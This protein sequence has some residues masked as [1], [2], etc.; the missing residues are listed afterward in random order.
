MRRRDR[1]RRGRCGCKSGNARRR[2]RQ[3]VRARI[4]AAGATKAGRC[5]RHSV[6][7]LPWQGWYRAPTQEAQA[8]VAAKRAVTCEAAS[9][10]SNK[11][12][13]RHVVRSGGLHNQ[14][15]AAAAV[16]AL[17]AWHRPVAAHAGNRS[18]R[19]TAGDRA[20][21]LSSSVIVGNVSSRVAGKKELPSCRGAETSLLRS[22]T[23]SQ[24]SLAPW[25]VSR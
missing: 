9:V 8:V 2:G 1:R 18:A 25:V 15:A 20:S 11:R 22:Q 4:G 7:V 17:I 14:R 10:G 6:W 5:T 23:P 16:L 3:S 24:R 12:N 13:M 19:S 21:D